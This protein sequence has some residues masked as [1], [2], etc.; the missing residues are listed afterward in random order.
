MPKLFKANLHARHQHLD[1][2]LV[3]AAVVVAA[4]DVAVAVAA[5]GLS[6]RCCIVETVIKIE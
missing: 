6:N 3:A 4:V 5:A 1:T 2:A